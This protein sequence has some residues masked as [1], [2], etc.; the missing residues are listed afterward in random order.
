MAPTKTKK[1]LGGE[2]EEDQELPPELWFTPEELSQ[3]RR[4]AQ[5]EAIAVLWKNTAV[6]HEGFRLGDW[7]RA[8]RLEQGL[9]VTEV[10]TLLGLSERTLL[11]LEEGQ[12]SLKPFSQEA[13][14]TIAEMIGLPVPVVERMFFR[15]RRASEVAQ[16]KLAV[17]E[18]IARRV[19]PF[20]QMSVAWVLSS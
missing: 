10:A 3:G 2:A 7:L 6:P 1:E 12:E 15:P 18:W 9:T 11:D 4:E 8:V 16:P 14:S 13:F 19:P 20:A 5:R 17:S